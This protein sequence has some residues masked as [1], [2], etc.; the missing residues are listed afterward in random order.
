MKRT[1]SALTL[2]VSCSAAVATESI[3]VTGELALKAGVC[4]GAIQSEVLSDR[5][6]SFDQD[7]WDIVENAFL[8]SAVHLLV[9]E[10]TLD[11]LGA[12]SLI[13]AKHAKGQDILFPRIRETLKADDETSIEIALLVEKCRS[14]RSDLLNFAA[15][16]DSPKDYW[17]PVDSPQTPEAAS[18]ARRR[19]TKEREGIHL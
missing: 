4:K 5:W 10:H 17:S 9:A 2:V 11:E 8:N 3:V 13:L 14:L 12:K 6:R 1:L 16:F 19:E 15:R 18:G 7:Q